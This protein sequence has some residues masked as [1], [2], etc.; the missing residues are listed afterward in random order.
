MN[1]YLYLTIPNDSD[2]T[3]IFYQISL[4]D[5]TSTSISIRRTSP[6]G[7]CYDTNNYLFTTH[8]DGYISQYSVS[9]STVTLLYDYYVGGT[10][11]GI[12][13]CEWPGGQ[14]T[15][16]FCK[17]G[18]LSK[19]TF[20]T[21]PPSSIQLAAGSIDYIP[22]YVP[23]GHHG[24]VLP[25]HVFFLGGSSTIVFATGTTSKTISVFD[26]S[27]P[28]YTNASC[29][30]SGTYI[31]CIQGDVL[32]EDLKEGDLVATLSHGYIPVHTMLSQPF[33]H[34]AALNSRTP[35]Q[36]YK[37]GDDLVVTGCHSIL[38]RELTVNQRDK[39]M[40]LLGD[41]YV[42]DGLYRLPACLL[43]QAQATVFQPSGF[44]TIYHFAL[45]HDNELMNY[46]VFANG[47]IVESCSKRMAKNPSSIHLHHH[48]H[49][50]PSSSTTKTT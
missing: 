21:S 50:C 9:G 34:P 24:M 10:L 25:Q 43:S 4:Y 28:L 15:L 13:S 35:S 12:T 3:E 45:E 33:Y 47:V 42:T 40:E 32:V 18:N 39:L 46:G 6:I 8:S 37:I 17:D 7:I 14:P 27:Y 30:L 31:R 16:L 26:A 20:T 2:Y 19:I 22:D 5:A 29:F 36:L 38:T 41:I 48:H 44:Y 1:G 11:G 23:T 49:T